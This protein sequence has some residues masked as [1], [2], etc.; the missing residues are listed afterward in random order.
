MQEP[1]PSSVYHSAEESP[2]TSVYSSSECF[3][4][5]DRDMGDGSVGHITI[6]NDTDRRG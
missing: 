6:M 3:E 5:G 2:H 1:L 4:L